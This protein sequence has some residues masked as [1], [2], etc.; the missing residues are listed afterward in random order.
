MDAIDRGMPKIPQTAFLKARLSGSVKMQVFLKVCCPSFIE[1][2]N[3]KSSGNGILSL[4]A[5]MLKNKIKKQQ[6]QQKTPSPK[7]S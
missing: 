3:F 7:S 5:S 4:R 2:T 1:I 6:Q